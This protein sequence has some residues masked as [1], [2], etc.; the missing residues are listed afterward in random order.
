MLAKSYEPEI[1]KRRRSEHMEYRLLLVFL[2][3][4]SLPIA[5]FEKLFLSSKPT[6]YGSALEPRISI[7]KKAKAHAYTVLPFIFM[8]Q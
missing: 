8:R 3:V 2:T 7:Y 4:V 6:R 5:L 1:S